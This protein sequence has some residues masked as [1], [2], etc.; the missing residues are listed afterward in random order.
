[1]RNSA[2]WMILHKMRTP[3]LVIIISY[4]ISITGLLLI[5]G[6]D[7]N[8]NAYQM[9]IFD[10]FYFVTYT[11]TTIGFG[12]TPFEFTYAQ[13]LWVSAMIYLS[14]IS[15]FYAVGTLV[16]LL[17]DK[18]FLSQIAQNK[19]KRQVNN[20]KESFVIILGYNYTTSE[21]I[22]IINDSDISLAKASDAIILG[23]NVRAV[24]TL[25]ETEIDE[26][27]IKYYSII[28]NLVEDIEKC[29]KGLYDPETKEKM[30]G[31]VEIRKVFNVSKHGKIAGCYV[32]SGV[33][34][35]NSNCR[36]IRDSV[37]IAESK[38]KVLKRFKDDAKEVTTAMECGIS[39][40]NFADFK[41]KD[42]IEIYELI[43]VDE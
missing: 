38:I 30:L 27:N 5:E 37:V 39:F 20:I 16:S 28:Y 24:S 10:A 42:L 23:F 15:W 13:R 8:G 17:Q 33:A 19:F 34:R 6:M 31:K 43:K 12:E 3:F 29:I 41:E 36:I 9:T 18:L 7:A 40:D 32:Q 35:R 2:L 11:A 22:K 26:V 25:K 14:V 21:I 1:M 4:T